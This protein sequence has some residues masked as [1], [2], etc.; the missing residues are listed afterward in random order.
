MVIKPDSTKR[1]TLFEW[2][3]KAATAAF[4]ACLFSCPAVHADTFGPYN[5]QVSID[6]AG[7]KKGFKS[8]AITKAKADWTINFWVRPSSQLQDET[9]LAGFGDTR[10][11]TGQQ[12]YLASFADGLRF[13]GASV[14]VPTT[15]KVEPG[16][17]Q[18]L[19]ATYQGGVIKIYKDGV[20]LVSQPVTLTDAASEVN[21]APMSPWP[22]ANN[23]LGKIARFT[24]QDRALSTAEIRVLLQE[25]AGLDALNFEKGGPETWQPQRERG[26]GG[27]PNQN[28]TTFPKSR[29]PLGQPQP[30][31]PPTKARLV[32]KA[33]GDIVIAGQWKLVESPKITAPGATLSQP[34]FNS[35]SWYN[36]TVPGTVLTTLVNQGVYPD[37]LHGL[38]NLAIP[39]S[40]NKQD[41]WYRVEFATPRQFVGRN[42]SL[43][44]NGINYRAE[45]WL[46]GNRVGDIAGAF[47][48]GIFAVGRFL[49]PG[50]S[51]ALAV[52][53]SPP[54]NPGIPHEESF[55]AGA[56]PNGG[57]MVG[58]GPTFFCSEGWDWIPG[59]RDRNTGIWQDVV[60]HPSD[61]VSL[62]DAKVV[63]RL[64]TPI[65]SKANV[66]VSVDLTNTSNTTQLGTLRGQFE[67]V[68]FEKK[69][70]IPPSAR[71]TITFSP[72][73]FAALAVANPRLW[74]PNGYGKP[75]MYTLRLSFRSAA[76]KVSDTKQLRFGMRE[77]SV[78]LR[79][80]DSEG[81]IGRYEFFPAATGKTQVI[82]NSLSGLVNT[83]MG[84]M[85][86]IVEGGEKS[87]ALRPAP[88]GE[89]GSFLVVKVNGQRIPLRG[90]NWGMDDAMKRVSRERLEPF[91]RLQ[92]DSN[93]NTIRN[94]C[95]QSTSEAFF[96]LCD[97]YGILVWNEFWLTTQNY[98]QEPR[99]TTLFLANA[100]DSIKRFRNHPSI[101]LWCGRNEGVPPAA[102][103]TG[104][105]SLIREYDGTRYYQPNSIAINL[106]GS[107]PWNYQ[108]PADYFNRFKG[109]T[110]ELGLPNPPSAD[111]L[112]AMMPQ[113][114]LWPISDNWVYHDWH[115][116]AAGDVKPFMNAMQ[117]QFGAPE[118]LDDF[119]RKAQMLNY[120]EHR[121]MY[122]GFNASLWKP[123]V[124]RFLWM[125]HPSWPSMSWQLYSSNY[126]TAGGYFGIQKACE[127]IHVQLNA[128]DGSLAVV[129][130]TLAPLP[131]SKLIA[132]V[133][134]LDGTLASSDDATIDVAANDVTPS[135]KI[136]AAS[137]PTYFVKLLLQ[138]ERG[139][140]LSHNFYWQAT[141]ESDFQSLNQMPKVAL[142]LKARA[143]QKAGT[144]TVIVDIENPSKSVA[145]MTDVVLRNA[146][147]NQR[148]LPVYSSENYISLLP[149]E[150]R[151]I[152]LECPTQAA[153]GPL[154]VTTDGW[155]ISPVAV[156]VGS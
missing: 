130:T 33:D 81:K 117:T 36:A 103:N 84:W 149:G 126:E 107:G 151:Q 119:A 42:V 65:G 38:N 20:E 118:N 133:Y 67:G 86:S 77:V 120:V 116:V 147:N 72:N 123:S 129:N 92:R 59:I 50:A 82:D 52:R 51:N 106:I 34:G 108:K 131:K 28:P 8:P 127:P 12:R 124:G 128:A 41:Y 96:D 69:V 23:F 154:T 25:G 98:N 121:A 134:N 135:F 2:A 143:R 32:E 153:Q 152:T 56:G 109:F 141:Q 14:D 91:I 148:I 15:A 114:D 83:R 18:M 66:T 115:Q 94:W 144:T 64:V 136:K 54:P 132:R 125:S 97:E 76:G 68:S 79:A 53:V 139:R 150:K 110:T 43:N 19:T 70:V 73:E 74:W 29:A 6:G 105:D 11:S 7:I 40:L 75:E 24:L 71:Q 63:T 138:D 90:G 30:A 87:P 31:Q 95:G 5:G 26:Q 49:K 101:V 112:R 61:A 48:R 45:V 155:N 47:T 100:E 55:A 10:N 102:I 80:F 93:F 146:S 60:L 35:A 58:D 89:T 13:W 39:E 78:E 156:R 122:E 137:S 99:D 142:A 104:L 62:G 4:V 57:S 22:S 21:L 37:P 3:T 1:L 27:N 46:N 88:D 9:L 140:L 145:L 113:A 85:P 16:K 44:F 111:T 17:W